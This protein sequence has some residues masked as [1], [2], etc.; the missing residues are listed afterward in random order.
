MVPASFFA[1]RKSFALRIGG[2]RSTQPVDL[3]KNWP[4]RFFAGVESIVEQSFAGAP[5]TIFLHLSIRPPIA[6]VCLGDK[7]LLFRV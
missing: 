1:N 2:G 7:T 6:S 5:L 4:V 3:G